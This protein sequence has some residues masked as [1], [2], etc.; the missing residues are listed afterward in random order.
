MRGLAVSTSACTMPCASHARARVAHARHGSSMR[1][2]QSR[3][4]P[5]R[6]PTWPRLGPHA[7]RT[8]AARVAKHPF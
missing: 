3:A 1:T 2:A 5:Q 4:A 8:H 6:W 7:R